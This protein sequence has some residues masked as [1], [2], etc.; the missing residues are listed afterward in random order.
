[1][2]PRCPSPREQRHSTAW[3]GGDPQPQRA[4]TAQP[5]D[6]GQ[7]ESLKS[8]FQ[9]AGKHCPWKNTSIIV[10]IHR[11]GSPVASCQAET[12]ECISCLS[13]GL[14]RFGNKPVDLD[15][16]PRKELEEVLM[17]FKPKYLF[18][19]PSPCSTW[20]T[21]GCCWPYPMPC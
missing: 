8:Q 2:C 7:E 10:S 9:P 16:V 3:G 17:V 20:P 11:R 15:L 5:W 4:D 19:V 1:M 6:A 21:L 13:T 14:E 12:P 18:F